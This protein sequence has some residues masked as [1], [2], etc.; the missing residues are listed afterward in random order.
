MVRWWSICLTEPSIPE[1]RGR[2]LR[3]KQGYGKEPSLAHHV[4]T[5]SWPSFLRRSVSL[6]F[7]VR[8]ASSQGLEGFIESGQVRGMKHTSLLSITVVLHP[9]INNP[10]LRP[11]CSMPRELQEFA[12]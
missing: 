7:S 5:V 10:T 1:R 8:R 12:V 2:E 6:P 9:K 3:G 4:V 11:Q